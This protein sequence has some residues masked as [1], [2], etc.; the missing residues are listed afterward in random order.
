[1]TGSKRARS[2]GPRR[3]EYTPASPASQASPAGPSRRRAAAWLSGG[4]AALFVLRPLYPSESVAVE[5]DGL[6]VVML[7]LLLLAAWAWA[8]LRE[9]HGRIRV[10]WP[11]LAL[12]LLAIWHS[13]AAAG[14][15]FW[16]SPRPALNMLWEWLG[17]AAAFFLARQSFRSGLERRAAAAVMIAVA[18]TV[19]VYGLYQVAIELPA[20]RA[21]Y[22]RASDE[23]LQQAGVWFPPG[24]PQR[25]VFEQRLASR[26]PMATFALANSLAGFLA[27]W[28]IAVLAIT[29]LCAGRV[30]W[31]M[32]AAVAG[33]LVPLG[34]CLLLTKSR[35]AYLAV[36]AGSLVLCG[37]WWSGRSRAMPVRRVLLA[38]GLAVL[39]LALGVA[40]ALA[41]GQ[42]DAEVL[43]EAPKSLGYR[44]EYWRSTLAMIG[45]APVFGCGPG[46]FQEWYTAYKLPEASEEIADPHNFLFEVWATAGTPAALLLCGFLAAFALCA[47]RKQE[48]AVQE[49]AGMETCPPSLQPGAA[50][51]SPGSPAAIY[52]GG[53]AGLGLLV[54]IGA[55]SAAPPSLVVPAMGLLIG[56]AALV[57]L[58][59]WVRRGEDSAATW[60]VAAAVMLLHLLFAGGIGFPGVASSLWLLLALGLNARGCG[61]REVSRRI[62]YAALLAAAGLIAGCF[63]TGYGA[64]VRA[65]TALQRAYADPTRAEEALAAAAEAD[66]WGVEPRGLLADWAY[67]E[68]LKQPSQ[69]AFTRFEKLVEETLLRAPRAA[70]RRHGFGVKFVEAYARSG[71][72]AKLAKGI[73]TLDT[74]VRLYPNNCRFRADLAEAYRL[75]GD[76][77]G[78]ARERKEALR[79]DQVTPHLDRKLSDEQRQRLER[80]EAG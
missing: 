27:P 14:A 12:G 2:K 15:F 52:L 51:A 7:W 34:A 11:D 75:A 77:K 68:W 50:G 32:R 28:S 67:E 66:R 24:S 25:Q 33:L 5:G 80:N 44:M 62:G 21:L 43:S 26:E 78:Y 57:L 59:G 41:L 47:L 13:M 65:R 64:T 42:L 74:A 4:A 76:E 16:G 18:A 1:M 58:D 23:T 60:T 6:V 73:E 29:L 36:G 38:A 72:P 71:D 54:P 69:A 22:Q 19:S 48:A 79:L 39:V 35:S 55:M 70:S 10:G 56:G 31:K 9:P 46:N 20:T 3:N 49:T 17:L 53:L 37:Q 63:F 30:G 40:G 61:C 8:L 45:D